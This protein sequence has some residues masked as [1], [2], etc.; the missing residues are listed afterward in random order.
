MIIDYRDKIS[1]SFVRNITYNNKNSFVDFGLFIAD[2]TEIPS[3]MPVTR[4]E[5]VPFSNSIW[6]FT[7]IGGSVNYEPKSWRYTFLIVGDN[8]GE[9]KEKAARV[10]EWLSVYQDGELRDSDNAGWKYVNARYIGMELSL[11]K[12]G[13]LVKGYITVGFIASPYLRSTTGKLIDCTTFT[14][15]ADPTLYLCDYYAAGQQGATPNYYLTRMTAQSGTSF[16][17][18]MMGAS[19]VGDDYV[20]YTYT[21]QSGLSRHWLGVERDHNG[22]VFT[23]EAVSGGRTSGHD[24][25]YSYIGAE[26]ASIAVKVKATLNG[27]TASGSTIS[28][29]IA[30]MRGCYSAGSAKSWS[31]TL[32]PSLE[33]MRI[34]SEGSPS[35]AIDNSLKDITDF[36]LPLLTMLYITNAKSEPCKIQY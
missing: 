15:N 8:D 5:Q 30:N 29:L 33:H 19:T 2:S 25:N 12:A 23:L 10:R 14:P 21:S 7:E 28:G 11:E 22:Y 27:E 36:E 16:F 35:L 9:I 3:D 32:I 4:F 6:D 31:K 20:Q 1:L 17:P 13:Y 18:S 26:Q 34:I 24:N